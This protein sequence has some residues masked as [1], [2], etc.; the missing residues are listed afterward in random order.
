MLCSSIRSAAKH[1]G[2]PLSTL[3]DLISGN[4]ELRKRGVKST[5]FTAAE[6]REITERILQ[7]TDSGNNLSFSR[8][9]SF[10]Q[11]KLS[12]DAGKFNIFE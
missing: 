7:E 4:R 2:I 3:H 5:R 12:I 10:L 11:R 1:Y 6:E 8:L 9:F